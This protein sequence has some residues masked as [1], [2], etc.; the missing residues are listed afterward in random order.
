MPDEHNPKP[1]IRI[2]P[3]PAIR[4]YPEPSISPLQRVTQ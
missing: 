3:E 2:Y 4:I 1:D